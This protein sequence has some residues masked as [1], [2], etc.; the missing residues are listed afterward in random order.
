[1]ISEH[2]RHRS[3]PSEIKSHSSDDIAERSD[4]KAKAISAL[5]ARVNHAV[6]NVFYGQRNRHF[7]RAPNQENLVI[8][9]H[10]CLARGISASE[11]DCTAHSSLTLEES[12][13]NDLAYIDTN[14]L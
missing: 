3:E 13:K 5:A 12:D 11:F 14:A 7:H 9:G 2:S 10:L 8:P 4:V 6:K 1:M